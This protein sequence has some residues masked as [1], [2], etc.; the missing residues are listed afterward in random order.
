MGHMAVT[1]VAGGEERVTTGPSGHSQEWQEYPRRKRLP[2]FSKV[3]FR[4]EACL[5]RSPNASVKLSSTGRTIWGRVQK[6]TR[7]VRLGWAQSTQGKWRPADAIKELSRFIPTPTRQTTHHGA[8]TESTSQDTE[9]V[10]HTQL[11]RNACH[12]AE[13]L[14]LV[15]QRVK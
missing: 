10:P 8:T 7:T 13:S 12:L 9:P 1:I 6:S 4:N 14:N 15:F 3:S 2:D 5:D 11:S